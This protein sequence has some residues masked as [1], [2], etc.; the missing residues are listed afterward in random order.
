[1]AYEL[2]PFPLSIIFV[3]ILGIA[4]FVA[5][6]KL[7]RTA[8]IYSILFKVSIIAGVILII[9]FFYGIIASML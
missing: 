8:R 7:R 4:Y 2:I 5:L 9:A 3:L 1:M 6:W